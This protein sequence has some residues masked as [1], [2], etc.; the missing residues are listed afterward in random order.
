ML[1]DC[2]G[3]DWDAAALR[4]GD[5]AAGRSAGDVAIERA[6]MRKRQTSGVDGMGIA[7]QGAK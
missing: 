7:S 1:G 6:A 5:A 4:E 2:L 3:D